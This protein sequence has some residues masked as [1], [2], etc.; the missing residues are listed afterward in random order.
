MNIKSQKII[1][2]VQAESQ[3][4]SFVI[5]SDDNPEHTAEWAYFGVF[6]YST[7]EA[8]TTQV[9]R[10]VV[11]DVFFHTLLA[12]DPGPVQP[13]VEKAVKECKEALQ[14]ISSGIVFNAVT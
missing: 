8:V 14:K 11:T 12:N 6:D 10:N 2:N 13:V 4:N 3:T 1:P 7:E 9:A 5:S